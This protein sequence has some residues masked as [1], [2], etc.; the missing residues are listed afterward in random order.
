MAAGAGERITHEL[1]VAIYDHLQ[2]LS[3]AFHQRTPEGRPAHARDRGRQRHGRPVLRHARRDGAVGAAGGRDDASCC[4]GSTRCS[5]CSRWSPRRCSC[6]VSFVFRRR[7]ATRARRSAPRGRPRLDRQRGAVGDDRREGVRRRGP[8]VRARPRAQRAAAWASASRSRGCRRAST[9]SSASCARS[10]PRSCTV[11][12]VIRVSH[13][14]LCPGDLIVFVSYTRKAHSPMRSFAREASKLTAALARADR[15]RRDPRRRRGAPERRTPTAARAARRD[16]ARGRL[17]SPTR[18]RTARARA[19]LAHASGRRSG[20]R[21]PAP[22]GA[23]KSTLGSAR[24]PL[25]RPDG[26]PRAD[27]RPR[28]ARLLARAGCAT[29]SRSCCRTRCCSP[30]ACATTSPT[31]PTPTAR[32]GRGRR[33][34]RPPRTTSSAAARRL[35]HRA[36]PAGRRA[37]RR[38]APA[39]RDRPH[40]AAQPAGDRARRADHRPRR[41]AETAVLDG[42]RALMDGRT[43]ILITHSKRLADTADGVGLSTGGAST[44]EA[45]SGPAAARAVSRRADAGG[46]D[47]D[48]SPALGDEGRL[49]EVEIGRV[50]LQARRHARALPRRGAGAA[51]R[52]R[53]VDDAR[54]RGGDRTVACPAPDSRAWSRPRRTV[55]GRP[56]GARAARR[57]AARWRHVATRTAARAGRRTAP[58]S[59]G[60]GLFGV[61]V[62]HA[63]RRSCGPRR[64]RARSCS[65]LTRR[66]PAR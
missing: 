14:A 58:G 18:E 25:L 51:R 38:P 48:L 1:R 11:V 35:R 26:G 5:R 37:L 21:S 4:C 44:A 2:R 41:R 12:G 17:A 32:G 28:R 66:A 6:V 59:S 46:G 16:R 19:S 40:A 64:A 29:R 22:S 15:D 65:A 24:R 23:G 20:S 3:L 27:R 62:L 8:R 57:R 39:H 13:G 34:A 60:G 49:G 54:S 50:G 42:L 61:A 43:T 36:R 33:R 47:A 10:P 56:A 63:E 45:A 53:D 30:A 52:G 31:A 55:A 7:C 9:G